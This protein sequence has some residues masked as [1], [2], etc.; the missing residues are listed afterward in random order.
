MY[1]VPHKLFTNSFRQPFLIKVE[2]INVGTLRDVLLILVEIAVKS[3]RPHSIVCNKRGD[4]QQDFDCMVLDILQIQSGAIGWS[5]QEC[6]FDH[7]FT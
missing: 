5:L 6:S 4:K 2:K 7:R 1:K 3:L